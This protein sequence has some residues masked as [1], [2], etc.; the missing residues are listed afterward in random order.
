MAYYSKLRPTVY[1]EYRNCSVGNNMVEG[2]LRKGIPRG[3]TLCQTCERMRI[4]GTGIPGR[5]I[6][7]R[8]YKYAAVMA[9]YSKECPEIYHVSQNCYLGQNIER[10]Q[11]ERGKPPT[12]KGRDGK[13]KKPRV[14]KICAR[15][16]SDGECIPGT[17]IPAEERKPTKAYYSKAYPRP[18]IYHVCQH[19]YLGKRIKKSNMRNGRP[20][21]ARLCVNCNRMCTT[22]ECILG[23][24]IPPP[25][26]I[27]KPRPPVGKAKRPV[28][29]PKPPGSKP[30]PS[31]R[32]LVGVK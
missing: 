20:K 12:F 5:P 27:T 14:C 29:R 3:A 22:G 4:A 23:A 1:H 18:K 26:R 28:S 31:I 21:R 10:A 11:L 6:L 19:C 17:P 24:P 32:E 16:C 15:L 7:P 25:A 9:Y 8:T 30:K 13:I 2:N